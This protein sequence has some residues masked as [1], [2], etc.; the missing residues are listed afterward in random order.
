MLGFERLG[1][2]MNYHMSKAR[3]KFGNDMKQYTI[4][5]LKNFLDKA[6]L[7]EVG[8]KMIEDEIKSRA[9]DRE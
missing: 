5:E 3:E 7:T 6:K 8:R 1:E 4:A 2:S 9:G